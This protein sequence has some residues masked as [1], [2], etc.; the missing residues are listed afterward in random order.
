[1]LY[2]LEIKSIIFLTLVLTFIF[3]A[4][5]INQLKDGKMHGKWVDISPDNSVS[6]GR[7]KQGVEVGTW[8]LFMDGKLYK[9]EKYKG[10]Q[11][12]VTF[13]YPSRQISSKGKTQYDVSG[14][15]GD[16]DPLYRVMLTPS[17]PDQSDP[18]IPGDLDPLLGL[19]I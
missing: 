17:I 4:K 2:N 16:T 15:S 14:Y 7:Y 10:N 12:N 11:A 9:K 1:M 6:K 3:C 13:Y 8:K 18:L 19:A 5:P